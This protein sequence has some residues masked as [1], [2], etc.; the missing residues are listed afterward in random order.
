MQGNGFEEIIA[1][2][3]KYAVNS[4]DNV[5][6]Y[7]VLIGMLFEFKDAAV[8][9]PAESHQVPEPGLEVGCYFVA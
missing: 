9:P 3:G 2:R 4:I 8:E 5:Y 6:F 7:V 1:C